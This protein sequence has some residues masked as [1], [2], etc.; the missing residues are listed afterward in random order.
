MGI[1][2]EIEHVYHALE[3]NDILAAAFARLNLWNDPDMLPNDQ[4]SGWYCYSRTWRPGR[5]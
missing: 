3:V 4:L 5:R 2:P 1:P